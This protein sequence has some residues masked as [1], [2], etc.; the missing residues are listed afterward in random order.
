MLKNA[1]TLSAMI[2]FS[3]AKVNLG[4]HV[5]GRRIDGFHDLES[6][7]VP[8]GLRD[9]IEIQERKDPGKGMEF[10]QSGIPVGGP[11][12]ENLCQKAYR[13]LS[14]EISLP[15][16]HLHL[17]KQIPVGAGLGGGSSNASITLKGLNTLCGDPISEKELHRIAVRLGSDCPFFL[18][19]RAMMMEGRGE[20]LSPA[21]PPLEDLEMV[22]LFAGIHISTADAYAGVKPRIPERHLAKQIEAPR[23]QWKMQVRNDFEEGIYREHSL[24][25]E[26]RDGLYHAGALYASMSGS[27]SSLYALSE[28]P[29]SLPESLSR[30]EI[31]RGPAKFGP[32]LN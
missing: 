24:L 10:S 7:M 11:G 8:V 15:P 27:G 2:L 31:W 26:I 17:H 30:Y 18:H 32:V 12:E 21:S 14:E 13:L 29:L 5:T 22:I 20:I 9:I 25:G 16:V 19:E 3:H 23:E 6:V 28:T 1:I 4:L